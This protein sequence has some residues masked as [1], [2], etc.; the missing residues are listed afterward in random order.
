MAAPA[1]HLTLAAL[2]QWLETDLDTSPFAQLVW[3]AMEG[4]LIDEAYRRLFLPTP[5]DIVARI[6]AIT[7]ALT[8]APPEEE[9]P[10]TLPDLRQWRNVGLAN[11]TQMDLVWLQGRADLFATAWP[12]SVAYPEWFQ[13][14]RA[15]I[16][17]ALG[18]RL[19]EAPPASGG[20][21]QG[22]PP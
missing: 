3:L 9:D 1:P 17:Q 4:T 7:T 8:T 11:C 16:G 19:A 21:G 13:R 14:R 2:R 20:P 15:A 12:N 22:P 10:V 18:V 5:P 6:H